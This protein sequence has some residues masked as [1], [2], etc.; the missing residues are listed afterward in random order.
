MQ[1]ALNPRRC[2]IVTEKTF[3]AN[4]KTHPQLQP[5]YFYTL[6]FQSTKFVVDITKKKEYA[7]R[8]TTGLN[9]GLSWQEPADSEVAEGEIFEM[10]PESWI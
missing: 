6:Q 5:I 10:A 1:F 4:E 2:T 3:R 8:S 7:P 9:C